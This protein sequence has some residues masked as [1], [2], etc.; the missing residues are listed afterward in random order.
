MNRAEALLNKVRE[1]A[2]YFDQADTNAMHDWLADRSDEELVEIMRG[3]AGTIAW[4]MTAT[5]TMH[6]TREVFAHALDQVA[7]AFKESTSGLV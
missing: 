3:A 4:R 7:D 5:D 2:G 1:E 6:P